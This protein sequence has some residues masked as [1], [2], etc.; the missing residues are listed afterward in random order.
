MKDKY[1]TQYTRIDTGRQANMPRPRHS[2]VATVDRPVID[3]GVLPSLEPACLLLRP[4]A[5]AEPLIYDLPHV[6]V[7]FPGVLSNCLRN[8]RVQVNGDIQFRVGTE[9]SAAFTL[10]KVIFP[11]HATLLRSR[12]PLLE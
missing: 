7:S 1:Y 8:L 6:C 10:R 4:D 2:T 3:R 5:F 11:L 9:E 12:G